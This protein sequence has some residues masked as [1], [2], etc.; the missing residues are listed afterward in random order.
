MVTIAARMATHLR[1]VKTESP[2]SLAAQKETD[3]MLMQQFDRSPLYLHIHLH[4]TTMPHG[5]RVLA[6]YDAHHTY[7]TRRPQFQNAPQVQDSSPTMVTW[8]TSSLHRHF[9]PL[10]KSHKILHSA[11]WVHETT[12]TNVLVPQEPTQVIHKACSSITTDYQQYPKPPP[13]VKV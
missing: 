3:A 10:V 9:E 11:C 12:T 2:H 4:C 5:K 6:L 8:C 7:F 1:A 13:R